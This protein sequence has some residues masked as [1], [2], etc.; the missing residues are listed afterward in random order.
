MADQVLEGMNK[1]FCVS[2]DLTLDQW[3]LQGDNKTQGRIFASFLLLFEL[4]GLPWNILVVVTVVKEKLYNQ[5]AVILLLNLIV[6]DFFILLV[7][8]PLFMTTGF[9]GEFILGSSDM[10][11]CKFC[12]LSFLIIIPVFNSMF[13]VAF[14]SLDRFFYIYKPFK[15]ERNKT[16]YTS[17]VVVVFSVVC[18]IIIGV[19]SLVLRASDVY[20]H[21]TL[22]VCI[23]S[24]LRFWLPLGKIFLDAI[25]TAAASN[26]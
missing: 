24:N 13:T 17:V 15:Y 2:Q 19:V 4:I 22:M 3:T 8:T 6:A 7:P 26:H 9:V 5:P 10:E 18:S 12:K 23:G 25:D 20:F 11:R 1:N 16:K 21:P 14:M